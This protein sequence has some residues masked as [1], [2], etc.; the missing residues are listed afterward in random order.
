MRK[1]KFIQADV[2]TASPFGGN[3]VVVI[4]DP[5]PMSSDDMLRLARGMNFSETS[6]VVP[7]T[8]P[9][10]AF[11]IRCY[12][13]TT[14][15]V[16]SG[17][18][19]IGT[20]Y[21]LA[22]LGR[23]ALHG[24]RTEVVAEV[25]GDLRPVIFEVEID[26]QGGVIPRVSTELRPPS[27]THTVGA[28]GYG[29]VAAA[30]SVDP[31]II[32]NAGLPMQ[33]VTT[34]LACLVVPMSSLSALRDLMPLDQ[35]LDEILQ[36]LGADCAL[37]FCKD[38]LSPANDLHVRVFAPPLGVTEDAA[39]GAANGAL[40]AYLMRHGELEVRDRVQLRCEQGSEMGR[41]SVIE[42]SIDAAYDPPKIHVGGRV[43][44]SAEGT[45]FY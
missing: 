33:L 30:L 15:V 26:A 7:T 14:E 38:T 8:S 44:L 6:F 32:L 5:G 35:T 40:A 29:E 24:P 1:V 13:P 18:Q 36:E 12:T 20:A 9:E 22:D 37:A 17:H 4:P 23:V 39:T 2:F 3:S 25:G 11:G 45:I 10:A 34:G 28:D 27:F 16:Y 31:M 19:L 42:V 21:V 41:P 43:S